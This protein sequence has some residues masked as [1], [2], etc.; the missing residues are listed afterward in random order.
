MLKAE[1]LN[2]VGRRL[3]RPVRLYALWQSGDPY[4]QRLASCAQA[5]LKNALTA[6][7]QAYVVRIE[8][9]RAELAASE[10]KVRRTDFGA[11]LRGGGGADGVVIEDEVRRIAK[12]SS[13]GRL[14]GVFLFKLI[15]EL[16]PASCLEMGTAL[17][18]S[19]AYQAAALALNGDGDLTSLEGAPELAEIAR[20]NWSSLGLDNVSVVVG[21][22]SDTLAT[23][24]ATAA[25][26]DYVFVDGHHDEQSTLG[27]FE[28]LQPYLAPRACLVFDDITWSPGMRRAWRAITKDERSKVCVDFGP[29]GIV[30]LG[31]L[32]RRRVQ[33]VAL[34]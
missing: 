33:R 25:P 12:A 29:M 6:E 8:R 10:E 17:G 24:A 3:L 32:A 1:T 34:A 21:K 5:A 2:K 9:L 15:R 14:W 28:Q 11:G 20:R 27:Y 7:E 18:I 31:D 23:A 13:K 22:F 4:L 30:I 26:L 16:R 19:G